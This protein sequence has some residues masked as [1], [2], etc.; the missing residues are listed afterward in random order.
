MNLSLRDQKLI[1]HPFTQA[2]T[3]D[4]PTAIKRASGSYVYD[5]NGKAYLDLISSWWV[6]LH[7]HAHPKIAKAIYEQA[8]TLEHVI[9]ANFTHA[10]AVILCEKLQKLLPAPL[11]RFFFSDNGSTAVE[12]AVKMAYQYWF[13]QGKKQKTLFPPRAP[14]LLTA[15]PPQPRSPHLPLLRRRGPAATGGQGLPGHPAERRGA[16]SEAEPPGERARDGGDGGGRG[17]RRRGKRIGAAERD[18]QAG[19]PPGRGRGGVEEVLEAGAGG[20]RCF[21]GEEEGS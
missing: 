18:A 4:L 12:T 1:W 15:K 21:E 7:G 8:L 3:T 6:N 5:E 16:G 2:K 13:N 9:F 19:M 20:L 10:P 11:I 17:G 14:P